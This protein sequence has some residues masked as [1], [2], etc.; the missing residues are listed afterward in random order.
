MSYTTA[1]PYAYGIQYIA[2][3][4]HILMPFYMALVYGALF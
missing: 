3:L 2:F 1:F 4:W